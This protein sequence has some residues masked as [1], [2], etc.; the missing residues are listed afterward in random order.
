MKDMNYITNSEKL[1]AFL[2]GELPIAE[3]EGLFFDV[4][5]SAQ[6][7]EELRKQL[8]ISKSLKNSL[9]APPP[10]LKN[11]IL[12]KTYFANPSNSVFSTSLFSKFL[13]SKIV[14]T[15]SS[16]AIAFFATALFF[17]Y[18][19]EIP[20]NKSQN[21][22]LIAEKVGNSQNINP[23][24]ISSILDDEPIAKSDNFSAFSP[25]TKSSNNSKE[26]TTF[27]TETT[28][29]INLN[30]TS[31]NSDAQINYIQ[32]DFGM[33]DLNKTVNSEFNNTIFIFDKFSHFLDYVHLQFRLSGAKSFNDIDLEPINEPLLN[34]FAIAIMY[35]FAPNHSIGLELGQEN[36]LQEFSGVENDIPIIWKQ[37][38]IGFWGGAAYQYTMNDYSI[39]QPYVRAFVGGTRIGPLAKATIGANYV[40][41]SK[42][43]TFIGWENT[44]LF[45]QYQDNFFSSYKSGITAGMKV[46][47]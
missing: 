46:N 21:E 2:D 9:I 44:G 14:L 13:N 28:T 23:P 24:I 27:A 36:F 33:F 15:L 16:A 38:Y 39:L 17:L 12:V 10:A 41:S 3:A 47:F 1:T 11:A 29:G 45:Y 7:Q 26:N 18:F 34:N 40:M 22:L 37:N 5:Q 32:T 43:S 4:A 25:I 31:A 6:L 42:F 30:N 19:Y 8:I 20:V 35:D